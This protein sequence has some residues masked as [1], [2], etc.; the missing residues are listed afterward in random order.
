[1]NSKI[2]KFV[3]Y[4]ST[5]TNFHSHYSQPPVTSHMEVYAENYDRK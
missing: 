3:P 2:A 1:M 4:F 5:F